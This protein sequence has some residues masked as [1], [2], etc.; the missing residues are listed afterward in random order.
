ML[1]SSLCPSPSLR[2]LGALALALV[3]LASVRAHADDDFL[4]SSP[5]ELSASHAS[6]DK[7]DQCRTCHEPDNSLSAARCLGCH[8]HQDLGKRVA[9]G[10]GFHASA[11]V[12]GRA[13]KLCHQEHRGRGFDLMGWRGVGGVKAFDHALTGWPLRGKHATADC[14]QCHKTTNRQGLRTYLSTDKT[15]GGCHSKDQPHGAIR[16]RFQQCDLCHTE[17]VWK[18]QKP[19]MDFDHQSRDQA[20]M[21]LQG[22]HADVAC[23]KCHPKAKFKLDKFDGECSQCHQSPHDG[24]LFGT[25]KCQTCHFAELRTLDEVRFDHRKQTGYALTGKHAQAACTTCHT[26]ALGTRKPE[27][28]CETCHA[29]DSKHGTRFAEFPACTTCHSARGWKSGFVFNHDER[30][31]FDLTAQ[32]Q[33]ATCRDCHRGKT[34]ALFERFDVANGCMSC[35]RHDKAHGGK[36]KNSECLSCHQEGGS[37]KMS[38]SSLETFHGEGSK[39]PLRNGHAGVACQMCHENDVYQETATECG[40]S[41]HEDSLHRG[42]LG[43]ECSR[44]HEPGLWNAVRFD[45][46]VD[47]RWPLQGKHRQVQGCERCHPARKYRGVPT[48]CGTAGCH[49]EDDLHQGKLGARCETCHSVEGTLLFRHDRDA[50]FALEGK[51]RQVL[52][53]SCH[54]SVTFKPVPTTCVGCHPEP[55]VHKGRYGLACQ[56]CHSVNSFADIKARHDVGDFSLAGAHDQLACARCHP[57]GEKLRGSGNL[58]VTCHRKDDVHQNGLSPRCGECHTQRAFSPARWSHAATGCALPGLHATLPCADCHRAG[59]YGALSPLCVSCHRDDS[60]RVRQP[61]H[62]TLVDCGN[63][64]NPSAWIPANQLG[65]QTLCR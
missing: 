41:C 31:K 40:A 53:A 30:T 46:A 10:E 37:K 15:C 54:R 23:S 11:A 24:Q 17:S 63:C 26:R 39:F 36:F 33:K 1:R 60:L 18:P 62:R 51:H 21:P 4:K 9:A 57:K 2:A 16:K 27:T 32:H 64:H 28:T 38:R 34:P 42:S 12:K 59:N 8:D 58:C 20:A 43:P 47:S 56:Q 61:D 13:C 48:T 29:K 44:C 65:Q 22:A 19:R 25:K 52:C 6:L 45:H 35:H 7:Q 5:G 3:A 55:A 50:Q 14:A 49:L